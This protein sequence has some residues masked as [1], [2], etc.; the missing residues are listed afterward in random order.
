MTM[1]F[2]AAPLKDESFVF[3]IPLNT[4]L[5]QYF[6]AMNKSAVVLP[7]AKSQKSLELLNS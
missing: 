2:G 1:F 7:I 5:T 3:L 6:T 4:Y